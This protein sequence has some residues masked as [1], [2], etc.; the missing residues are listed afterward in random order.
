[1]A[2][3]P[4]DFK[5]DFCF[6]KDGKLHHEIK[7]L[8]E[9]VLNL[10]VFKKNFFTLHMDLIEAKEKIKL[11][12]EQAQL[13]TLKTR[14]SGL[15]DTFSDSVER[16][17]DLNDQLINFFDENMHADLYR[18]VIASIFHS[19]DGLDLNVTVKII[20]ERESLIH[21]LDH[22]MQDKAIKIM[23]HFEG[24]SKVVKKDGCLIFYMDNIIFYVDK[25]PVQDETKTLQLEK[26]L[27]IICV[28][29][30]IRIES[31]CNLIELDVLHKNIY[32]VFT[33][34][35]SSYEKMRDNFD[36]QAIEISNL[37][38]GF[39]SNLTKNLKKT[40]LSTA[41]LDVIKLILHDMRTDL[42][43]LLTSGMTIDESFLKS[44]VKLEN[45]YSLK[46]SKE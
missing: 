19:V 3:E 6:T 13:E 20:T 18:D 42:N 31:L 44:I 2:D 23:T 43:L 27:R 14:I 34:T 4:M 33:K 36:S 1:M 37:Y 32:N 15:P 26:F 46:Y 28:G 7:Y 21:S 12:E 8:K 39:E 11:Y 35:R 25:M 5:E 17:S 38:L 22:K 40:N 29:A 24:E 30:N 16:G 9:R 41:H 10:E 45:A